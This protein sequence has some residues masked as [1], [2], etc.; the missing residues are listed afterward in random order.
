[1]LEHYNSIGAWQD[2]DPLGGTIDGTA[3]VY[4]SS[5][6]TTTI[7]SPKD[8]MTH[9]STL[10]NAQYTY[11]QN[12]VA[13]A[14]GRNA[15]ANDA[16][17]VDTLTSSLAGSSYTISQMMADYTQADSFSQRTQAN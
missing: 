6:D 4:F 16:C 5:T 11:A 3:D 17:T 1:V 15:N 8:L 7:S 13:F 10:Q 9:I 14:T 12:W 2:K